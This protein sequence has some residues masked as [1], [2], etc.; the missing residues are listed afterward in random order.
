MPV[1]HRVSLSRSD[2][3]LLFQDI[4]GAAHCV[5]EPRLT[6][7]LQFLAQIAYVDLDHIGL[8]VEV[9]AP[10]LFEDLL[11]RQDPARIAQEQRQQVVLLG[12]KLDDALAPSG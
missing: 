9:I 3:A 10:G 8:A 2:M 5:D 11:A 12:G 4:T 6:A 7:G 1:Y